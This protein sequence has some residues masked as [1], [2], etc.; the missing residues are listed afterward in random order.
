MAPS[1]DG[2]AWYHLCVQSPLESEPNTPMIIAID[3]PAGSGKSSVAK[4][5]A[6]RLGFR[7]LDTGAM[8][9]AVAFRALETGVDPADG[10]AVAQIVASS[11]VEFTHVAGDPFPT[12]VRIA[13]ADVTAQ[14]RTPAVDDAVSAV[15]SL[16]VVREA[17][18]SQQR[19]L[20]GADDI[21]VEGRDIGTVVFPDAELKVFLTASPEER[22][23]RRSA[24]Q[25]QSGIESDSAGVHEA[26]IR[27]D[28]ADS[29]REM[30]PLV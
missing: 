4:S 13:G 3:G 21:V 11:P 22:A 30:S 29:T 7:Y 28:M 16:R 8:Y 27:R 25:A 20:G 2:V 6:T 14:I 12:G 5:V 10:D 18:V 17:M 1:L 23:R 9:R 24:Q 26:I 15:A 19:A